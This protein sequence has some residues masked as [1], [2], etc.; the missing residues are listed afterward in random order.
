MRGVRVLVGGG[1]GDGGRLLLL[2]P[3]LDVPLLHLLGE[4]LVLLAAPLSHLGVTDRGSR[5]RLGPGETAPSEEIKHTST[6]NT[7]GLISGPNL[8]RKSGILIFHLIYSDSFLY[9]SLIQ[10]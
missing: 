1:V 8:N 2:L 4:L 9:S 3:L 10:L 7:D 6:E 5:R